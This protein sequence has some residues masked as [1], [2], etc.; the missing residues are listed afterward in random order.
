MWMDGEGSMQWGERDVPSRLCHKQS[1]RL[2]WRHVGHKMENTLD[3]DIYF[4]FQTFGQQNTY[5]SQMKC[6]TQTQWC[7]DVCF[8]I[9]FFFFWTESLFQQPFKGWAV[10]IKR[11]GHLL[12]SWKYTTQRPLCRAHWLL[13]FIRP[14]QFLQQSHVYSCPPIGTSSCATRLCQPLLNGLFVAVK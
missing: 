4:F 1:H 5:E 14:R 10:Q 11:P 12:Q 9:F 3:F 2:S 8:S 6:Q 7:L 13:Y